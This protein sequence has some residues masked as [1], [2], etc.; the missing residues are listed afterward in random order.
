MSRI[1]LLL[2]ILVVS[3]GLPN[4]ARAAELVIGYLQLADDPRYEDKRALPQFLTAALGPSLPGAEVAVQESKFVLNSLNL[5]LKLEPVEGSTADELV[6][7]IDE[8]MQKGAH[9]FLIDAPADV[10]AAVAAATKGKELMLFNVSA[11]EDSLRQTQ[12][13]KHLLHVL[14]NQ[15]MLMDALVQYLVSRK[16]TK[17]LALEGPNPPDK[18]LSAAFERSAKRYGAK[19]VEKRPFVLSNDPRQRD[20]NNVALLTAGIDYDVV[21]IADASGEFARD[22]PYRTILPR[23]VVGS[24]G[25]AGAAWHWAWERQGAPQLSKR[26][27]K[28]AKRAMRDPDW[29]AWMAVKI[30]IEAMARTQSGDFKTVDAFIRGTQIVIDGFKGAPLSFRPWDNQLRQPIFLIT[31]NWVI[32]R[33]PVKGFLHQ[34]NNLDTLGFDQ[35]D[36]Q[37]KF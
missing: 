14:P 27:E 4:G 16:W 10:V 7:G 15:G 25:L 21:F 9:F 30:V 13:Q 2:M 26:F 20:Q 1:L 24:E 35:P 31:H 18:L 33:A 28:E 3:C 17:V 12:C 37:C 8:L 34:T 11:P 32:E 19:I 6:K 23:P 22:T 5:E 36:S 29:A